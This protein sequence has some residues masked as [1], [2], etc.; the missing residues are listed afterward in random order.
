MP[1]LA[2]PFITTPAGATAGIIAVAELLS[3]FPVG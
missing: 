3:G 1:V 2:L